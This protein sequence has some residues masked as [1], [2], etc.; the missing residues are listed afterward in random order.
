M[1]KQFA[2]GEAVQGKAMKEIESKGVTIKYWS[3]E[4]L[5]LY[6]KDLGRSRQGA[7]GEEPRVQEGVG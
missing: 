3:K 7:G 4:M 5:D 6:Q 1:L 2:E